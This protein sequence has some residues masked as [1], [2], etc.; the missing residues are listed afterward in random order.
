M[1]KQMNS[2]AVKIRGTL[3]NSMMK[4]V[5]YSD[6]V[7]ILNNDEALGVVNSMCQFASEASDQDKAA[8]F[9]DALAG[10]AINASRKLGLIAA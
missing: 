8:D 10:A 7:A 5:G 2:K 9:I 4:A 6:T 1:A 3:I